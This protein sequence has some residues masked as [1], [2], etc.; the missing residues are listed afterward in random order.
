L[1]NF[2]L[3]RTLAVGNLNSFSSAHKAVDNLNSVITATHPLTKLLIRIQVVD[4]LNS[5]ASAHKAVD[6]LNSYSSAHKAVD[7]STAT[8]PHTCGGQ[9]QHLLIRTH[10]SG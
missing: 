8:H 2:V 7:I 4:N 5:Y 3:I 9:S 1:L 10:V 6:N